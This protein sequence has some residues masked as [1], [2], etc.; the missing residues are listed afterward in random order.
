M[1]STKHYLALYD[2]KEAVCFIIPSGPEKTNSWDK[3]MA[4]TI[5]KGFR[6]NAR[7][8]S[9]RSGLQAQRPCFEHTVFLH[10]MLLINAGSTYHEL[11]YT[12]STSSKQSQQTTC[13]F[14]AKLTARS[15]VSAVIG[16]SCSTWLDNIGV[17]AP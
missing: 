5:G 9:N 2:S 14:V 15:S 10:S 6:L 8:R 4:A 7:I 16:V 3:H 17:S 1:Q 12:Q 13:E 11:G